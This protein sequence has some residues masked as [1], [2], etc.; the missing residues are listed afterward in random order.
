[1]DSQSQNRLT[2]RLSEEYSFNIMKYLREGF[3]IYKS[4][5]GLLIAFGL[6]YA[7]I[8]S[9]S[10]F[11]PFVGFLIFILVYAPLSVG[12]MYGAHK[13]KHREQLLFTD[14]FH[15]F[16][17][18]SPLL[19]Q[20]LLI[21]L[22]VFAAAIPLWIGMV[23]EIQ[24]LVE[25]FSGSDAFDNVEDEDFM[26]VVNTFF[27][28]INWFLLIGLGLIPAIVSI[29]FK[30]SGAFVIFFNTSA[31]EGMK[32]SRKFLMKKFLPF[33][34]MMFLLYIITYGITSLASLVY[35]KNMFSTMMTGSDAAIDES[36]IYGSIWIT[37]LSGLC[38]TFFVPFAHCVHYAA[39]A[40]AT[41]LQLTNTD[42]E[43]D[44]LNHLVD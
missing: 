23:M 36:I 12:F 32:W 38:Y 21:G 7:A 31:T 35:I 28:S 44:I 42:L 29:L 3:E 10:G 41:N 22:I 26:D 11:I 27:M 43:E 24:Q 5:A 40:D 16:N 30:W 37:I 20:M 4:N 1:M 39:F 19:V 17:F 18:F 15:G 9:L 14:F 6:V 2:H 33:L 25:Q 34:L 8:T 13:I